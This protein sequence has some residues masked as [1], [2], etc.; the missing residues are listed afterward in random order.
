MRCNQK[1][2]RFQGKSGLDSFE[3]R[4]IGNLIA[5]LKVTRREVVAPT[6]ENSF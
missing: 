1:N 4:E 5:L 6:K 3:R 2:H